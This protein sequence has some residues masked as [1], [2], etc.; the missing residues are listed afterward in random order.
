MCIYHAQTKSRLLMGRTMHPSLLYSK[1]IFNSGALV[2]FQ[3]RRLQFIALAGKCRPSQGLSW[4]TE[5]P[6]IRVTSM[7]P[8]ADRA[9]ALFPQLAAT[10]RS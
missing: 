5:L 3:T 7:R 4:S 6:R 8:I 9:R 2:G 1:K 10:T